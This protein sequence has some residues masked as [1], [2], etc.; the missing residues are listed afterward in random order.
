MIPIVST[1]RGHFFQVHSLLGRLAPSMVTSSWR[2][3]SLSLSLSFSFLSLFLL[4]LL[5]Q[6]YLLSWVHVIYN[7]G[8]LTS[9]T[10]NNVL[11]LSFYFR[12]HWAISFSLSAGCR[13]ELHWII[14]YFFKKDRINM[15]TFFKI[16]HA[17]GK[18]ISG[19]TKESKMESNNLFHCQLY[20]PE[21][22]VLTAPRFYGCFSYKK[23]NCVLSS[24]S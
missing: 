17:R 10:P 13:I 5:A 24:D 18:R 21:T 15:F 23:N 8:Q 1:F 14:I 19:W 9:F 12:K 16:M 3:L 11:R 2:I 6:I 22:T 7:I 20:F 4:L